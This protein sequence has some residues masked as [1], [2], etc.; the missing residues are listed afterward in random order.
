MAKIN[1]LLVD[2]HAVVRKG[3]ISL[4]EDETNIE[5]VGNLGSGKEALDFVK[6]NKVDLILLDLNM[7]EMSGIETARQLSRQSPKIKKLVF[8]MHNDASYV[9]KSIENGVDGY[10]LKDSEKEEIVTAI[11]QVHF[12]HKYFPPVVSAILVDA[13]QTSKSKQGFPKT[14]NDVLKLLSKKELEIL[15]L[16]AEGRSSQDIANELNLSVRTVSNHRANMLRKT[17]LN[18]TTEL[19]GIYTKKNS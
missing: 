6:I 5:V 17:E 15:N 19:V 2:D 13:L 16:V 18:N 9:M 10:L 4:L 8:S 3:L 12:G 7:P 1:I 11:E 14:E